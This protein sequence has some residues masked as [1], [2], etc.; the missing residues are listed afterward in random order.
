MGEDSWASHLY[1]LKG[2]DPQKS[3]EHF[4]SWQIWYYKVELSYKLIIW[5]Y[6]FQTD[7]KP[8]LRFE[9][10]IYMILCQ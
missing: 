1:N 8:Q 10:I 6:S 2:W 3:A 5:T 7:Q 9:Y 4:F